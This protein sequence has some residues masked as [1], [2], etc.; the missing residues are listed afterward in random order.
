MWWHPLEILEMSIKHYSDII[1]GTMVSQITSLTI[2]Y[3]T[4][5]SGT[6]QRKH[7]SSV[8]LAFVRGIHWSPV[9]SLH[10]SPVTRKMFPFDDIIMVYGAVGRI[11]GPDS[12]SI[13]L[14]FVFLHGN[15][16]NQRNNSYKHLVKQSVYMGFHQ[17]MYDLTLIF[18]K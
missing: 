15:H 17:N 4:V 18:H 7:Q 14:F 10:K 6:Y 5:Y 8:S 2:V 11:M 1:M 16:S 3:S 9:N 13:V 12:T